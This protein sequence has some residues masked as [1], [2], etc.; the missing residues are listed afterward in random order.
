MNTEEHL[1]KRQQ[2]IVTIAANTAI[3][4]MDCHFQHGGW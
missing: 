1:D 3:G 4:A 2:K